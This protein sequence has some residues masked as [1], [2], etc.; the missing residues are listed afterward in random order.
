MVSKSIQFRFI[1]MIQ[2]GDGASFTGKP[3]TELF[4]GYL[5]RDLA[6]QASIERLVHPAHAA[7]A[8][9]TENLI[10]SKL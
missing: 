4:V 1:G 9:E 6:A 2:R 7:C 5:D 10:R 3:L 8:Q